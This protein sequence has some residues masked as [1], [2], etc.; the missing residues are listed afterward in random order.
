MSLE[1]PVG[2]KVVSNEPIDDR[3]AFPS[4]QKIVEFS[5]ANRS[6]LYDGLIVASA[7]DRQLFMWAN[8]G[9]HAIAGEEKYNSINNN[10]NSLTSSLSALG[11]R[12]TELETVTNKLKNLTVTQ[13][14]AFNSQSKSESGDSR[15]FTL[16][17]ETAL[18]LFYNRTV[19]PRNLPRATVTNAPN[20]GTVEDLHLIS[21]G[22]NLTASRW[23]SNEFRN[24]RLHGDKSELIDRVWIV[25]A[26]G[27]EQLCSLRPFSSTAPN[28]GSWVEIPS[29]SI[30]L[31]SIRS[32][33]AHLNYGDGVDVYIP[34]FDPA[35]FQV[36]VD[37]TGLGRFEAGTFVDVRSATELVVRR[38][39]TDKVAIIE[40]SGEDITDLFSYNDNNY[41]F[42]GRIA[43]PGISITIKDLN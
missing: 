25:H 28:N 36:T 2:F 31:E 22:F 43:S 39:W 21:T 26:N 42:K 7:V 37:G 18:P 14:I 23:T 29:F 20:S 34:Y 19:V 1:T 33:H 15:Q 40:K 27:S 12:V 38:G 13:K 24:I 16:G 10:F 3:I 32:V 30:K 4:P 35:K 5:N 9:W 6:R 11:N 17:T 8:G 41:T